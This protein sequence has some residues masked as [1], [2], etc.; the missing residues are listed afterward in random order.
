MNAQD[1]NRTIRDLH[2]VKIPLPL[3]SM[4]SMFSRNILRCF[5][6]RFLFIFFRSFYVFFSQ[7]VVA[8]CTLSCSTSVNQFGVS[9][10][11]AFFLFV[12]EHFFTPMDLLLHMFC[13]SGYIRLYFSSITME[14][15]KLISIW[16]AIFQQREQRKQQTSWNTQARYRVTSRGEIFFCDSISAMS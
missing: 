1:I 12:V 9:I 13:F 10:H 2:L 16:C 3:S 5:I 14:I 11:F 6:F 15:H 8:F 7:L 4:C